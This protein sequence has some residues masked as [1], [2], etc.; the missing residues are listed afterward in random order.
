MTLMLFPDELIYPLC[1]NEIYF[2][3][4]VF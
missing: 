4:N 2:S 3:R 1:C